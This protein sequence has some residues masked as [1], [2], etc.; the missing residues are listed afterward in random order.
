MD[1]DSR[2]FAA[3]K[4]HFGAEAAG[5]D[6]IITDRIPLYAVLMQALV[7]VLPFDRGQ[8]IRIA[9]LGCGTGT[10]AL[11]IKE[12]FPQAEIA[13]VDFSSEMLAAAR[14]KHGGRPGFT[15]HESDVRAFDL[16][17]Y[18]AAAASLCLH[19]I[20]GEQ[21]KRAFY[22]K[23]CAGLR[24]GGVF[25]IYDVILASDPAVQEVYLAEWKRYMQTRLAPAA[26]EDTMEKYR[27]ED[28]PFPLMKELSFLQDAG[29]EG[30]D[31]ICKYYNGAVYGGIRRR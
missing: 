21:E 6:A 12:R 4:E 22:K 20:D 16:T 11:L 29:F 3:V 8:V 18:D 14:K 19:H 27:A 7:N 9:D 26:I 23:V 5:F 31:V 24:P 17:G 13:C 15:Y 30:V 28:R 10:V 25:Y 1:S 2:R